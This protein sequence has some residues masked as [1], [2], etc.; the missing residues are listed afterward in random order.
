MAEFQFDRFGAGG[1]RH[2]LVPKTNAEERELTKQFPNFLN[3]CGAFTGVSRAVRQHNAAG[4]GHE[5]VL[6]LGIVGIN[7]YFTA[8]ICQLPDD[9]IFCAVVDQRNIKL[10]FPGS[11]NHIGSGCAFMCDGLT[12]LE[13][14][15]LLRNGFRPD[16]GNFGVYNTVVANNLGQFT[17]IYPADTDNT[18][19]F[20]ESV[21]CAL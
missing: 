16:V 3:T 8:A 2:E 21:K 18:V 20:Q 13:C 15:N 7:S 9:V 10:L 5:N 6:C 1:Q 12:N 19:F 17:G 14:R 11:G 4:I